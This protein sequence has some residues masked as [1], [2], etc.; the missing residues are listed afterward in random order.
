[1]HPSRE[2]AVTIQWKG[3]RFRGSISSLNV[4]MEKSDG[5]L[6]EYSDYSP[7]TPTAILWVRV[8]LGSQ[9][10]KCQALAKFQFSVG[11]VGGRYSWVVKTESAKLW[12]NFNFQGG[13]SWVIK[14]EIAKYLP[15]FNLGGGYSWVVKTQ[16]AKFWPNFN[17][18]E[19]GGFLVFLAK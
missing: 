14:T 9:N 4:A 19:G 3:V 13:Y 17:F 16:S 15:N 12:S 2:H 6:G 5:I 11:G 7:H 8:F 1:M 10:S 18:R